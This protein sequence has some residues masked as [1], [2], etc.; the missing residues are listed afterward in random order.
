M[1]FVDWSALRFFAALVFIIGLAIWVTRLA[2]RKRPV[3]QWL[4]MLVS[5]PLGGFATLLLSLMLLSQLSGCVTYG[6]PVFSPDH[7]YAA[8]IRTHDEG[9]TGGGSGVVLYGD[10]GF[11]TAYVFDGGWLS[12]RNEDLR[13]TSSRDLE[14]HYSHWI[15]YDEERTCRSLGGVH[16]HCIADEF[17]KR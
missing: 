13:W 17:L 2:V 12:V 4:T 7:R 1:L 9:A 16:V 14:V 6:A 15:T 11:S 8:R 5:I 3:V 10:H